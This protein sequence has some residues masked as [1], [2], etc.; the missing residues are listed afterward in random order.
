MKN[1]LILLVVLLLSVTTLFSQTGEIIIKHNKKVQLKTVK[2]LPTQ[3]PT[4]KILA[5]DPVT[6]EVQYVE[7]QDIG[8]TVTQE[9]Y[10]ETGTKV[11]GDLIV[12]VGEYDN[13]TSSATKIV[14]DQANNQTQIK[15]ALYQENTASDN[16]RVVSHRGGDLIGSH[17]SLPT[18]SVSGVFEEYFDDTNYPNLRSFYLS[19]RFDNAGAQKNLTFTNGVMNRGVVEKYALTIAMPLI[20]NN[21][22]E[23]K[24]KLKSINSVANYATTHYNTKGLED[25]G[26]T[27][28]RNG[29][30]KQP[31]L[32]IRVRDNT[33]SLQTQGYI[34]PNYFELSNLLILPDYGNDNFVEGYSHTDDL[35]TTG[36]AA[37]VI[38]V[39]TGILSVD[40]NGVVGKLKRGSFPFV[41]NPSKSRV[42]ILNYSDGLTARTPNNS[43]VVTDDGYVGIGDDTPS[44]KL[45]V[46]GDTRLNGNVSMGGTSIYDD[47]ILQIASN[48]LNPT[49][50]KYGAN[51]TRTLQMTANNSKKVTGGR[52]I[53][54]TT[55]SSYNNTG[56][57]VGGEF[58]AQTLGT[59]TYNDLNGGQFISYNQSTGTVTR[60]NAGWFKIQN[61]VAGGTITRAAAI[62][63]ESPLNNGTITNLHGIYQK[64]ASANN[65]FEGTFTF[66]NYPDTFL[67]TN[68]SGDLEAVEAQPYGG[69]GM[70]ANATATIINTVGTFEAI[71][72]TFVANTSLQGITSGAG[73]LLT[74][75][76][77]Q[78]RHFHI[79]SNFDVTVD[80]NNQTVKLQ[81]FHTP[82]GGS[83]V[84]LQI[85]IEDRISTGA[86]IVSMSTHADVMLQNGDTLQLKVTN[87]TSTANITVKNIYLF[88]MGM[89]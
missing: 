31:V 61:L 25:D 71:S 55:V 13:A 15:G 36:T 81:W 30:E 51:V 66:D 4:T 20:T 44:E 83:E 12:Q 8:E 89:L 50:H 68:S 82:S 75:T 74:Y 69:S 26:V 65:Y 24:L 6:S 49:S 38:G 76:G 57:L 70:K 18:G 39:N 23:F 77:T 45:E 5:L 34:T 10:N 28:I 17:L 32:D 86:D 54:N 27:P 14:I 11:G 72:G 87:E 37:T 62:Y 2:E 78:G 46:S 88:A 64:D 79:V 73:G 48:T 29:L 16:S 84:A 59:G 60:A 47:S 52:F 1:K 85:P 58:T 53:A 40:S 67:R 7:S 43:F 41:N 80:S 63:I 35:P 3:L 42:E 56:R 9:G 21:E 19:G 22:D 33:N